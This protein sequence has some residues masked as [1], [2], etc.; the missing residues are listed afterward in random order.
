MDTAVVLG[1]AAPP[2]VAEG[3]FLIF[4]FWLTAALLAVIAV[5]AVGMTVTLWLMARDLRPVLHRT[6]G[7]LARCDDTMREVHRTV[8]EAR[9]L[10]GR[11]SELTDGVERVVRRA[12]TVTSETVDQ[13]TRLAQ[14]ARAFLVG[15]APNGARTGPRRRHRV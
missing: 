6:R 3:P 1:H 9:R 11:T 13:V 8:G 15:Q 7:V 2:Q 10:L 5:C 14:R 12:C 4:G